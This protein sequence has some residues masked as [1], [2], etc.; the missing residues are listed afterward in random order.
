MTNQ[1]FSVEF[2]GLECVF[3]CVNKAAKLVF[4]SEGMRLYLFSKENRCKNVSF[5]D[6]L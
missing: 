6:I 4:R 1:V 3:R 2:F 5:L